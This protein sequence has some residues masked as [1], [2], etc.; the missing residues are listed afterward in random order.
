MPVTASTVLGVGI[1]LVELAEFQTSVLRRPSVAR[2]VFS[3]RELA[4]CTGRRRVE[5]LAARF[6][7]K[8][9]AFKAVGTGWANG[10]SLRDVEVVSTM[11]GAPRLVLRGELRRRVRS[12][13]GTLHVSLSH[14]GD[15]ATAI[16]VYAR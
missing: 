14:S 3:S 4:A 5:R 16:V 2:L 7:A 15:Y 1:D 12:L 6:A 11:R 10:M 13:G 8:E 9:A